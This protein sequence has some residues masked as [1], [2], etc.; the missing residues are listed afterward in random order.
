M[1]NLQ[2]TDAYDIS[3]PVE[4]LPEVRGWDE[5]VAAT[6]KWSLRR[7]L[8]T[9]LKTLAAVPHLAPGDFG[10]VLR[11]LRTVIAKDSNVVCVAEVG[12][13]HPAHLLARALSRRNDGLIDRYARLRRRGERLRAT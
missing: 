8:L 13:P 1:H 4:I 2:E 6:V 11:R 5:E 10:D 12:I 7:D 9:K 3:E